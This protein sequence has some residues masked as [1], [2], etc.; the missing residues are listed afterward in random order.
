MGGRR[1]SLCFCSWEAIA[2]GFGVLG[3][4]K[5]TGAGV[6]YLASW[7]S[8]SRLCSPRAG[9]PSCRQ[10][11]RTRVQAED[12]VESPC[13]HLLP[14]SFVISSCQHLYLQIIFLLTNGCTSPAPCRQDRGVDKSWYLCRDTDPLIPASPCIR[15]CPFH[16]AITHANDYSIHSTSSHVSTCFRRKTSVRNATCTPGGADVGVALA[17][18]ALGPTKPSRVAK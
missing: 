7:A 18:Q 14:L 4:P 16:Q 8:L 5:G 3:V 1:C 11:G 9:S 17:L 6:Q 10:R 15:P 2:A 12:V 13:L